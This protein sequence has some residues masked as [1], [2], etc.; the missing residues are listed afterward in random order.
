MTVDVVIPVY[1][2]DEGFIKLLERLLQQ[3]LLPGRVIIA[4]TGKSS[5][6]LFEERYHDRMEKIRSLLGERFV[7]FHL[8]K[9]EF[10]H[11]DT[12]N[13]AMEMAKAD[14]VLVMTMDAIPADKE[15][16]GN[17]AGCFEQEDVAV[18][19]ARQLPRKDATMSERIARNFNYPDRDRKKN[20]SDLK[21]LGI[22]TYF[23]SDVCAMYKKSVWEACGRFAAPALFNED[24][25]FAAAA[26]KQG[27]SVFYKAGAKVYH[28]HNYTGKQQF[29]R[30][31]D[32]AVSQKMHPEVFEG[33][34]S[35]KEGIRM[36][37]RNIA[38]LLKS[39]H[40]LEIFP[41]IYISGCK[42]LGYFLGKRYQKLPRS[43]V[44]KWSTD[45]V[46]WDKL[47]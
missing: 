11:A 10:D 21:E 37:R 2:P 29:S 38:L 14:L 43:L 24:M 3:S 35:E 5:W 9:E 41:L 45:P 8:E 20:L 30:N 28:S 25:V 47:G 42:Y 1:H 27:Y 15:L 13:R 34:S 39:G 16:I 26:M 36:L 17:L 4:N 40:G 31:F 33:I 12:R 46:F 6:Q 44:R 18:A 7:L 23:C 22:K 32:L 19:Y